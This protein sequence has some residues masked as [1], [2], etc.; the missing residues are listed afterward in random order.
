MLLEKFYYMIMINVE[1]PCFD[2]GNLSKHKKR[3]TGALRTTS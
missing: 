1:F 2:K 3:D